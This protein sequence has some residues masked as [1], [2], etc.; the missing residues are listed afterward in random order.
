MLH[1]SGHKT[2]VTHPSP[3]ADEEQDLKYV[4]EPEP[5]PAPAPTREQYRAHFADWVSI[6]QDLEVPLPDNKEM[7]VLI[8]LKQM[9]MKWQAWSGCSGAFSLDKG[10]NE[11]DLTYKTRMDRSAWAAIIAE[12]HAGAMTT[13]LYHTPGIRKDRWAC[14]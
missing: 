10:R 1:Q 3:A 8:K 11:S 4:E 14:L 2:P 6:V 9:R 12:L 13:D 7:A 5:E